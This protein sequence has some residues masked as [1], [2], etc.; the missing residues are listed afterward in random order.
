M[1]LDLKDVSYDSKRI[2]TP[3]RGGCCS[4]AD[5]PVFDLCSHVLS[6]VKTDTNAQRELDAK[7]QRDPV[8]HKRRWAV[9]GAWACPFCGKKA[10]CGCG[11]LDLEVDPTVATILQRVPT[12]VDKVQ[13]HCPAGDPNEPTAPLSSLDGG[14]IPILVKNVKK[15]VVWRVPGAAS[16]VG[17]FA[18]PG[19]AVA[20]AAR[21]ENSAVGGVAA[22]PGS[23]TDDD[24]EI[25]LT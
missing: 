4:R 5:A 2:C 25:D 13:V 10:H 6:K 1:K 20:G 11:W 17:G 14:S 12:T 3:A 24:E 22:A 23:D 21:A 8:K 19:P 16:A 7:H 18:A 15:N 9:F